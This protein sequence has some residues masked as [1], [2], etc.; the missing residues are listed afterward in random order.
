M[1]QLGTSRLIFLIGLTLASYDSA[2]ST[3]GADD[4]HDYSD[5]VINAARCRVRCLSLLQVF[6]IFVSFYCRA[7]LCVSAAYAVMR[8]P[9]ICPSVRLSVCHVRGYC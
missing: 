5:D 2:V 6:I 9:S 4:H 1:E 7:M 3:S 8:C